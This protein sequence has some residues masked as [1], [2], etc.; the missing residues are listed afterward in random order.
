VKGV[1]IDKRNLIQTKPL[2]NRKEACEQDQFQKFQRQI[3]KSFC[4]N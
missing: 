2:A 4:N 1:N 3:K